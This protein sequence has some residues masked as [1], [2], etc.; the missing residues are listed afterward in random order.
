VLFNYK[1]SYVRKV[2]LNEK[3]T[4]ATHILKYV[5]PT[6]GLTVLVVAHVSMEKMPKKEYENSNGRKTHYH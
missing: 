3:K 2:F 1:F 6:I 4:T 5:L